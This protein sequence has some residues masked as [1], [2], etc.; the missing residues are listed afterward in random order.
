MRTISP[1]SNPG[2]TLISN[3]Q[4]I[5]DS[6]NCLPPDLIKKYDIQ[7]VPVGL[8]INGKPYRDLVEITPQQFWNIFMD[9]KESPSTSAGNPGDF[10]KAFTQCGKTVTDMVCILVSKVLTATF[11]SAFQA[12][13]IIRADHPE[14]NIEIIDS[15]TSAGALG[16][17]VLEAARAAQ[18]GKNLEEVLAVVRDMITRVIYFSAL[19]TLKYIMKTGRAPR[20]TSG[21]GELLK[22]KPI[23]GFIDD[24]GYT[25]VIGRVVGKQRSIEK[26]V[27]MVEKYADTTQPLH[28]MVHYSN[29]KTEGEELKQLIAARYHCAEIHLTEYTP[30]MCSATGPLVGLSFYS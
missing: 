13:K 12:R 26:L 9:L 29:N 4:I 28:M 24:S 27:E 22:V 6:T 30:V 2:G 10:I 18:E 11:E 23:I 15:R 16:F 20:N 5:T 21:L 25:E 1:Y 17:I 3:V 7:V 19:D 8:I 14:Y